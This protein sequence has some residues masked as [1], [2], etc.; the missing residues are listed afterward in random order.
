MFMN[1]STICFPILII[2]STA[3]IQT[4]KCLA[5]VWWIWKLLRPAVRF[6][7]QAYLS[8]IYIYIAFRNTQKWFTILRTPLQNTDGVVSYV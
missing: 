8:Y 6:S 1:A 2:K 3:T 7:N 5:I 4:A